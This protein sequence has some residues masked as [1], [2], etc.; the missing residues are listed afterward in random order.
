MRFR[1]IWT[2]KTRFTCELFLLSHIFPSENILPFNL[3]SE[4]WATWEVISWLFWLESMIW[5]VFWCTAE[6]IF[7]HNFAILFIALHKISSLTFYLT[8]R[9]MASVLSC[10]SN[11]YLHL[12]FSVCD[13]QSWNQLISAILALLCYALRELP[14]NADIIEPILFNRSVNLNS[15]LRSK[16]P[17]VKC[18][19]CMLLRIVGRF[20]CFA[21]QKAWTLEMRQSLESLATDDNDNVRDVS[22]T[23]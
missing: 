15:L 18:Q 4:N 5:R 13:H 19:I 12:S 9:R 14:E 6:I 10:Q 8:V 7:S 20:S 17:S 23:K 16:D 22:K 2:K 21:L 11:C 3:P 1:W